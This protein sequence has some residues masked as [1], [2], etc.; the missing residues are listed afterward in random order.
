MRFSSILIVVALLCGAVSLIA[1][2]SVKLL[3]AATKL[4]HQTV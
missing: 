3:Q 1:Q 2:E 4:L